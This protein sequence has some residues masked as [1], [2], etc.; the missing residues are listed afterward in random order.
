MKT[1]V[2][3]LC[4]ILTAGFCIGYRY[5][6]HT[7]VPADSETGAIKKYDG[8]GYQPIIIDRTGDPDAGIVWNDT[9]FKHLPA[10][11]DT[12]IVV[13]DANGV[14]LKFRQYIGP[15]F[16]KDAYIY[17]DR[18]VWRLQRRSWGA[19]DTLSKDDHAVARI[20]RWSAYQLDTVKSYKVKLADITHILSQADRV[21]VL[22]GKRQMILERKGLPIKTFQIN[23]GKQPVGKKQFENDGKT[24]EGVYDL[25]FKYTRSDVYYKSMLVSYP[26]ESEKLYAKANGKKPGMAVMIHGTKPD[27]TKAKDWTA[28]CIALQNKDMDTLFE[29][30][31]EGTLI[32]IRP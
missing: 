5:I 12:S 27:K 2:L 19:R 11:L 16:N 22:K 17:Q 31:A 32:E 1:F 29:Y 26:N 25:D 6:N 23:L 21:L 30:V 28:G 8:K 15:V 20:A 9:L 18:G 13:H 10:N 24:P 7:I 3:I 14:P 4:L